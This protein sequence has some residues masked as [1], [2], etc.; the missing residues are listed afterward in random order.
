MPKTNIIKT[1][2][3]ASAKVLCPFWGKK[4]ESSAWVYRNRICTSPTATKAFNFPDSGILSTG[5][6]RT[7]THFGF[8]QNMCKRQA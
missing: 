6:Q 2:S 3:S 1:L 5:W 4:G 8:Q 7:A